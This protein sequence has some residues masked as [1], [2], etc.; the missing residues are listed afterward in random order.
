MFDVFGGGLLFIEQDIG[1]LAVEI[2][3]LL[4]ANGP[5]ED[6]ASDDDEEDGDGDEDEDDVHAASLAMK[7]VM[8][9]PL[10][11]ADPSI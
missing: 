5:E 11:A 10:V 4:G 9:H 2:F 3:K 7:G 8:V 1:T 6:G